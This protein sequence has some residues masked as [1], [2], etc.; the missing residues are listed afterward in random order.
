M[1]YCVWMYYSESLNVI[2]SHSVCFGHN[3]SCIFPSKSPVWLKCTYIRIYI[4]IMKCLVWKKS[5]NYV[6]VILSSWCDLFI[7]WCDSGKC[8]N[9]ENGGWINLSAV[10][11]LLINKFK[12]PSYPDMSLNEYSIC[13]DWLYGEQILLLCDVYLLCISGSCAS[14]ALC[15]HVHL[16]SIDNEVIVLKMNWL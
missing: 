14:V 6:Y 4:Y 5:Q 10:E 13:S 15:R 16:L 1:W 8:P 7:C 3:V 2:W 9:K 11:M 12:N